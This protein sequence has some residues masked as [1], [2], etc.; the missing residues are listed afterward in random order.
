MTQAY[1][2]D[3]LVL[4]LSND[5]RVDG[6]TNTIRN[7]KSRIIIKSIIIKTYEWFYMRMSNYDPFNSI[8]SVE[9]V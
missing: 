5:M 4:E 7:C 6:Y 1:S 9:T 8:I 2:S 3:G